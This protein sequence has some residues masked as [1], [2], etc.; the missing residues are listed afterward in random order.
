MHSTPVYFTV[1]G[2]ES[3][4][5]PEGARAD[6][7]SAEVSHMYVQESFVQ[8]MERIL[9]SMNV[10]ISMCVSAQLAEAIHIIPEQERVR[11]GPC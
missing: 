10:E 4:A 5:V 7:L 1:G 9:G 3:A 6:E 11:P 2:V 8:Q